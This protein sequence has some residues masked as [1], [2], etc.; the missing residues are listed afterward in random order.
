VNKYECFITLLFTKIQFIKHSSRYLDSFQTA[1]LSFQDPMFILMWIFLETLRNYPSHSYPIP[2]LL[3]YLLKSDY[4][5]VVYGCAFFI[6]RNLKI[7]WF[8]FLAA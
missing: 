5:P 7:S 3:I 4:F 1:P 6:I 8:S 2:D